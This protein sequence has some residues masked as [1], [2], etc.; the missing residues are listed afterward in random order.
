MLTLS[1]AHQA[2]LTIDDEVVHVY[3]KRF[4]KAEAVA[5]EREFFRHGEKRGTAESTEEEKAASRQ[6]IEDSIAAYI[7]VKEG[8]I[9]D[10]GR[11]V[12]TGEDVIR[13]FCARTDVLTAFYQLIYSQNFLGKA[14]KKILSEQRFSF[15]GSARSMRRLDGDR[16]AP[17]ATPVEP[18]SSAP[19]DAA[20]A[21][22][23]ETAETDLASSGAM[24]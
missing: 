5:F 23:D 16:P 11:P 3:V 4:V 20:T 7:T 21:S 17:I 15:P 8:D 19:I 12:T 1:K 2:T 18:S 9:V 24:A 13:A 14:Q 6:Y 10:D 22:S